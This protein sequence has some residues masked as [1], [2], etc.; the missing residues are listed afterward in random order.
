MQKG[1]FCNPHM[2][3]LHLQ[4]YTDGFW[5]IYIILIVTVY[6]FCNN[7]N[8]ITGVDFVLLLLSQLRQSNPKL[9]ILRSRMRSIDKQVHFLFFLCHPKLQPLFRGKKWSFNSGLTGPVLEGCCA[10]TQKS[11][12]RKQ[13]IR[14]SEINQEKSNFY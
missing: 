7:L 12:E 2:H 6:A 3:E 10:V 8:R 9:L 4:L 5:S 13:I 1:V 11:P 14:L